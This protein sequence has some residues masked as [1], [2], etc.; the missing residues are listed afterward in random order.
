MS[1]ASTK[2]LTKSWST[3]QVTET[4][5]TKFGTGTSFQASEFGKIYSVPTQWTLVTSSFELILKF[6]NYKV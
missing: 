6:L 3:L 2:Y 5:G 1:R 4:D